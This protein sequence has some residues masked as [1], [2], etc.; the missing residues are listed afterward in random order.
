EQLI[1]LTSAYIESHPRPQPVAVDLADLNGV[2]R[3]Y[4]EKIDS[5]LTVKS[6]LEADIA[7]ANTILGFGS[8]LPD[9]VA[10]S[11]DKRTGQL[12]Y[13]PAIEASLIQYRHPQE[14]VH[15]YISFT[16]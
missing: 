5:L 9:S 10:V 16:A 7:S 6:K 15:G 13:H 11:I 14:Y 8:W 12:A 4:L 2:Q 3:S 1:K